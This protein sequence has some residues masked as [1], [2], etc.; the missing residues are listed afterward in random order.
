MKNSAATYLKNIVAGIVL[1]AF[2][3]AC[4]AAASAAPARTPLW[5]QVAATDPDIEAIQTDENGNSHFEVTVLEG[6]VYI[7]TDK[8]VKVEVFTILGQLVT[9][10]TLPAG[11][12]RLTIGNRGIYIIKGAGSTKRV[13]L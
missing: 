6:K 11:V 9:S 8:P 7:T 10:K 4:P 2:M 12:A 5:E 3:A 1:T 13:N